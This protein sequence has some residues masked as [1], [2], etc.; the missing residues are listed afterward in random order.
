MRFKKRGGIFVFVLLG[1]FCI[2]NWENLIS[3]FSGSGG[4]TSGSPYI[5]TNC[6]QLQEMNDNL[7]AVYVLGNNINCSDTINWNSGAGF[8]PI[9]SG[10]SRETQ[11][12]GTF[13][14]NGYNIT[15]LY[16][17]R[18][19]TEYVGLFGYMYTGN[20]SNVNLINVNITGAN[21]TGG[22]VGES[23]S[24]ELIKNCSVSGIVRGADNIGG[25]IG[26][27]LGGLVNNSYSTGNVSGNTNV[28][29]LLGSSGGLTI[30]NSYS[31]GNVSGNTNVGG[32]LGVSMG[33][34][35]TDVLNCHA[36]GDVNANGSNVG[37][38]VGD[39]IG[40]INNSYAT[41]NVNSTGNQVG[42]LIGY[43]ST[44]EGSM[45]T[46]LF[47]SYSI[48]NVKGVNNVGGLIGHA[49][50]STASIEE[51]ESS[52]LVINNSYS[53]GNV[54][55]TGNNVGGLI[56]TISTSVAYE[57]STA[58]INIA[59]TY[60]TGIVTST[61]SSVGG[62]IGYISGDAYSVLYNYNSYSTGNV[63][64][65]TN[66]GGLVGYI[67]DATIGSVNSGYWSSENNPEL[68]CAGHVY[69]GDEPPL[70][71]T[72][73]CNNITNNSELYNSSHSV[74]TTG[75]YKWN[76]T[77]V[78]SQR[79]ND[80]PIFKWQE[81][82]SDT[83][84]AAPNVILDSLAYQGIPINIYTNI[85]GNMMLFV[86][87]EVE[88]KGEVND[89]DLANWTIILRNSSGI[90]NASLCFNTSAVAGD[91]CS[92]NTSLYCSGECEN[93]TLIL[94][95]SDNLGNTN[96]TIMENITIDN[97]PPVFSDDQ[98][99]IF[100]NDSNNVTINV[101]SRINISDNYLQ[102]V[103]VV[104]L[105]EDNMTIVGWPSI[106]NESQGDDFGWA[107]SG[108]YNETWGLEGFRI[109]NTLSTSYYTY[110]QDVVAMIGC[111]KKNT[112]SGYDCGCAEGE[113]CGHPYY[114]YLIYN[115]SK[116]E[117]TSNKPLLGVG[118]DLWCEDGSCIINT[119]IIENGISEFMFLKEIFH[120][121]T[122]EG[123]SNRTYENATEI[124]LFNISENEN[125][126][127]TMQSLSGNYRFMF[128]ASDF[129]QMNNRIYEFF[130]IQAQSGVGIHKS[131]LNSNNTVGLTDIAKFL[132][133]VTNNG[134]N[135][136]TN[137]SLV[138]SYDIDINYS[139]ASISPSRINYTNRSVYWDNIP[140]DIPLEGSYAIYVNFSS[141]HTAPSVSNMVE[142]TAYDNENNNFSGVD[143]IGFEIRDNVPPHIEFIDQTTTSS[144]NLSQN[145]IRANVSASDINSNLSNVIIYLYNST[146]GIA[147]SS[148]NSS[149]NN[150]SI[151][152]FVNFTNLADGTYYLNATA[153]DSGGN[154]N[155]TETRVIVLDM[156]APNIAIVSPTNTTYTNSSILVNITN[157][158]DAA[159][160]WWFNGTA[161][162]TYTS[163]ITL[164][165]SND[166]YYFIAYAND[167]A[168][169]LNQTNVSFK[170]NVEASVNQTPLSS[171]SNSSEWRMFG[172]YLNHTNWDGVS[173]YTVLGLNVATYTT[174]DVI[175]SSPAVANGYV[176]VGS[177]DHTL[178][179]LNAS[180]VSQLIA[181]YTTGDVI[182]SSPAVANGYV[183][184][185]SYDGNLYQL[186]ASNVSQK[187][188]N[189][190]IANDS[191]ENYFESSP[192]IANG[193]VYVGNHDH[194]L[195]Q[196]N[197]SNVSE[198]IANYTAG[199][200]FS[201]A[202]A[203]GYV[204]A[205]DYDNT[206]YQLNASNVSQLITSYPIENSIRSS[207]AVANGYV[208]VGGDVNTLY[209]LNASNVSELIANYT[210][211]SYILSSPAVANGYVYVGSQDHTLYQLNA[212]NVSQK[213]SNYTTEGW[214]DSS[215]A[216]ANGYVYV[217]SW[218]RNLYQLNAS[219]VSQ[220]IANYT[221]GN[222]IFSSPA[223]ANGYVYF[224]SADNKTYQLNANNI[225]LTDN[226]F[227]SPF[228]SLISPENLVSSTTNAYNFTFN[229]TDNSI[230]SNCSLIF[231]GS[232][233]NILTSVNNTGGT[234]SM[235]NSS[236]SVA[237]HTWSVNCTD[238]PGNVGNSSTRTLTVTS[239]GTS[240]NHGGGGGGGGGG[241]IINKTTNATINVTTNGTSGNGITN[242]TEE[243]NLNGTTEETIEKPKTGDLETKKEKLDVIDILF[244][245]VLIIIMIIVIYLFI[246]RNKE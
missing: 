210:T 245:G 134:I 107:A 43:M 101:I 209:Q 229:V 205:G 174:G 156:H 32:L 12:T 65:N 55:S 159:H 226:D 149:I 232:I 74:Y 211:G 47:Y 196:L 176:Y 213:I 133:N 216:I 92:W 87:E 188:A 48:G 206:L 155:W 150:G 147:N 193:Y 180:N 52:F 222:V 233:I 36:T 178:Y 170:V 90:V 204:Y 224:G 197:A 117:N 136:I 15:R 184:V 1:I 146:F 126:N 34:D 42:G 18:S 9:G 85:S 102:G 73:S 93:Y 29:G 153:N 72:L 129:M 110:M 162:L 8:E 77:T 40:V 4:G 75:S 194:N 66:V 28:G 208:Y 173:Y 152:L 140:V 2:F 20:I 53:N 241:I 45:N 123:D 200:F 215:P 99:I 96:S 46:N 88:I 105:N 130:N 183:Y 148:T 165:L 64:G 169:N 79:S 244:L 49:Y 186:N 198:L 57:F 97:L 76:F 239:S 145:S 60:A 228:I 38:L 185:G 141:L 124:T 82:Q 187:I 63:S 118:S 240:N 179:Q 78:W 190:S 5:I 62:L 191:I 19:S 167:S 39:F 14:G 51:E 131:L 112:T 91:F 212:S 54:N 168:G 219:N 166:N 68:N 30:L 201:P 25:L 171:D 137:I 132:I 161:N 203:N 115:N 231:D 217:G 227:N 80:Y 103:D 13:N 109:N 116:E 139:S 50:T 199:G 16:I 235:Y 83:T 69:E 6:T 164:N 220:L 121:A 33:P 7:T 172:K 94:N 35:N 67:D 23:D 182:L 11:F 237:A 26:E 143:S 151:Y 3:A 127:L 41:G 142:V 218:D 21:Y 144:G 89:T 158:S 234:N 195:Y 163:P 61:G 138:D 84:D 58:S 135:N 223:V 113:D 243:G 181:N 56:G 44:G 122:N 70:T 106:G 10:D 86:G 242:G 100:E 108:A 207:P 95:A 81:G 177:Q 128:S 236:L 125:Q 17:N 238:S 225:S 104:L 175:F 157:S 221:A 27:M 31:T 22:L 154:P 119:S 120:P 202:V 246:Q 24:S 98:Q 71:Y 189:Y 214:V 192:A 111:F 230:V 160:V 59:K 37:G 114:M